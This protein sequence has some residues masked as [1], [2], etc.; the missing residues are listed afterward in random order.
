MGCE[1][2]AVLVV[3]LCLIPVHFYSIVR[4]MSRPLSLLP[5]V[6]EAEKALA[7]EAASA[8]AVNDSVAKVKAVVSCVDSAVKVVLAASRDTQ[9]P[10]L[11][12]GCMED[13]LEDEGKVLQVLQKSVSGQDASRIVRSGREALR[14]DGEALALSEFDD[15]EDVASPSTKRSVEFLNNHVLGVKRPQD[16][17]SGRGLDVA[18]VYRACGKLAFTDQMHLKKNLG[19][20]QSGIV[21]EAWRNIVSDIELQGHRTTLPSTETRRGG[22]HRKELADLKTEVGRLALVAHLDVLDGH[23]IDKVTNAKAKCRALMSVLDQL[24]LQ[25]SRLLHAEA[26]QQEDSS[27]LAKVHETVNNV[28]RTLTSATDDYRSTLSHLESLKSEHSSTKGSRQA[29]G[30][31]ETCRRVDTRGY[32]DLQ[33]SLR[34]YQRALIGL[35]RCIEEA[36]DQEASQKDSLLKSLSDSNKQRKAL[37]TAA[38]TLLEQV[39]VARSRRQTPLQKFQRSAFVS[40]Y[41]RPEKFLENA[42]RFLK[43]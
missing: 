34:C 12:R 11:Q 36:E 6:R 8:S 15:V 19:L 39:Q 38:H 10:A 2:A 43:H 35:H 41:L 23:Y 18:K 31:L 24:C 7:H 42:Q 33:N 32:A 9:K 22:S 5:S 21:D 30:M 26:V 4:N 16:S 28:V 17:C 1:L 29:P 20:L 14:V 13:Y 25:Q 3:P 37:I 27:T 40:F